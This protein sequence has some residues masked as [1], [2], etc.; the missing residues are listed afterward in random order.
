[1]YKQGHDAV[2]LQ[3]AHQ[4]NAVVELQHEK[5]ILPVVRLHHHQQQQSWTK[6]TIQNCDNYS[7]T[8]TGAAFWDTAFPT[9]KT[10]TKR[11][12]KNV[13]NNRQHFLVAF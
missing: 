12:K 3:G 1:M 11:H 2:R 6:A 7:K 10:A 9:S 8:P 13:E 4:H 5:A